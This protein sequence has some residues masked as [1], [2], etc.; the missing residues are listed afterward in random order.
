MRCCVFELISPLYLIVL[1][2]DGL[3]NGECYARECAA[4]ICGWARINETHAPAAIRQKIIDEPPAET[5]GNGTPITLS[6]IH[7]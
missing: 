1:S 7:I 6:L 5:N 2:Y 4:P 3:R